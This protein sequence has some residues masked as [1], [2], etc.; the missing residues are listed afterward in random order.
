M[1]GCATAVPDNTDAAFD[2]RNVLGGW[3]DNDGDV[4]FL[5]EFGEWFKFGVHMKVCMV[6]PAVLWI[7]NVWCK[8]SQREVMD[9][10][11]MKPMAQNSMFSDEVERKMRP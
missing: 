8:V 4:V 6:K 5:H 11:V 2:D 7:Q 3:T 10:S 9:Q 1:T